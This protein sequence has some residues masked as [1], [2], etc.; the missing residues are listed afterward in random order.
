MFVGVCKVKL[1]LPGRRSIKEKRSVRLSIVKRVRQKF[2]VSIAEIG[3]RDLRQTLTFGMASVS[4]ERQDVETQ[5]AKVVEF[6][7]DTWHDI[8]VLDHSIEI[9]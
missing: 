5:L 9:M 7:E 4:C 6:I 1:H 3:D 8:R 2:N